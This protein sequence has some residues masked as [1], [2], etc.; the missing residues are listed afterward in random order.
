MPKPTTLNPLGQYS[1]LVFQNEGAE[2]L[3][4]FLQERFFNAWTTTENDVITDIASGNVDVVILDYYKKYNKDKDLTLVNSVR[5]YL[6]NVPVL[7]CIE[8][9]DPAAT[10]AAYEAGA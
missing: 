3:A 9:D 5:K 10:I 4:S 7:L 6:P 1:I 2:A 8:D